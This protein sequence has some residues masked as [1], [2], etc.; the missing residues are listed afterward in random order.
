M[1]AFEH[2]EVGTVG[3]WCLDENNPVIRQYFASL[4]EKQILPID[5]LDYVDGNNYV[6]KILGQI[7]IFKETMIN[8]VSSCASATTWM[9]ICGDSPARSCAILF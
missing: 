6:E 5:V 4:L 3:V 1:F 7:D 9:L 8:L 2:F